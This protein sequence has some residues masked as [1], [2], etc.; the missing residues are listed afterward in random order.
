[1]TTVI[2]VPRRIPRGSARSS[3]RFW[4]IELSIESPT[5]WKPRT[6]VRILEFELACKLAIDS[7]VRGR[8][9]VL[10]AFAVEKIRRLAQ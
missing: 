5:P 4:K 3:G 2:K 1:M 8:S 10:L 6:Q 9:V 7:G